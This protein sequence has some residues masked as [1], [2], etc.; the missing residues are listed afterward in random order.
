MW[1]ED[2]IWEKQTVNEE[3]SKD[4]PDI[5]KDIKVCTIIKNKDIIDHLSEKKSSW[6]KMKRITTIALC[7]EKRLLQGVQKKKGINID[8]RQIGLESLEYVNQ[9]W[10]RIFKIQL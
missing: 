6:S 4:D 7:Y 8:V 2:K 10:R 1:Q 5:K 9:R 3:L